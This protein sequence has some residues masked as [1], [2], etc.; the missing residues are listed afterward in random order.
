MTVDIKTSH[1]ILGVLSEHPE[2]DF[3]WAAAFP[4][5][6]LDILPR[7]LESCGGIPK[8]HLSLPE[9]H[10]PFYASA[11]FWNNFAQ[12][13]TLVCKAGDQFNY[14][15]FMD[16]VHTPETHSMYMD[17]VKHNAVLKI[18]QPEVWYKNYA[19]MERLFYA[20]TLTD[21]QKHFDRDG[22]IDLDLK[23][24]VLATEG[25]RA[26]E[27]RLM[28]MNF[29]EKGFEEYFAQ[30]FGKNYNELKNIFAQ[31]A[32]P[33]AKDYLI[34]P[35]DCGHTAFNYMHAWDNYVEIVNNL[36][37]NGERLEVYD[38]LRKYGTADNMLERAFT[39]KRLPVVFTPAH[40]MGRLDDMLQVWEGVKPD[41]RKEPISQVQFEALYT[42][43][44]NL[45]YAG[46]ANYGGIQSKIDLRSPLN[47]T[48]AGEKPVYAVGLTS[49]WMNFDATVETLAARGEKI[50]LDDLRL[51]S[52]ETNDNAILKA[53]KMGYA[54]RLLAHCRDIGEKLSLEDLLSKDSQ[55]CTL[56][57]LLADRKQ[58]AL[59]FT[60][61]I[62]CGRLEEMR[63]AWRNVRQGDQSQVDMKSLEIAVKQASFKALANDNFRLAPRKRGLN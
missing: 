32:E 41:W 14:N 59:I 2:A 19:E 29:T 9:S 45:T 30:K 44:E 63:E 34:H 49:F 43:A 36:H 37:E 54:E 23:R 40:W 47:D 42:E 7:V 48:S 58:L 6:P 10:T 13:N 56:I 28:E 38:F 21:R 24:A 18:F 3:M 8:A 11:A 53:V 52:G 27:D 62:W 46:M 16:Q 26:V 55:Q 35:D 33:L 25:R 15:D 51:R 20:M 4:D 22:R 61:E 50:T 12:I 5:E 39:F 17:A 57:D 31:Y 60:P 1:A